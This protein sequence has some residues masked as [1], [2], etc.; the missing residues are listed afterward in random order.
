MRLETKALTKSYGHL[1][2]LDNATLSFDNG[3][4]GI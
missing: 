1:K 4:Y 3:V 2:A